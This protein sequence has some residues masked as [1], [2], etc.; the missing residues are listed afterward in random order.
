LVFRQK[1]SHFGI[2][3]IRFEKKI[4]IEKWHEVVSAFENHV[5]DFAGSFTVISDKQ[6]RIKK[7]GN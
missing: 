1:H 4:G 2:L 6:I 5:S 3:L 7:T